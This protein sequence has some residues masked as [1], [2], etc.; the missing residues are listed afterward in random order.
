MPFSAGAEILLELERPSVKAL[1]AH[2]C[3]TAVIDNDLIRAYLQLTR[4]MAWAVP[5]ASGSSLS[6]GKAVRVKICLQRLAQERSGGS[7]G[8][9]HSMIVANQQF[10]S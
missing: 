6:C 7:S 2:E 1:S 10:L 3:M 9:H 8:P 5:F 4:A